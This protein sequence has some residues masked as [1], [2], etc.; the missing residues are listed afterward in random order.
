MK[1]IKSYLCFVPFL[2]RILVLV[3]MPIVSCGVECGLM[4]DYVMPV[5]PLLM[6]VVI[7]EVLADYWTFGGICAREFHGAE[8]LKSSVKGRGVLKTALFV[9][10]I[11]KAIWLILL[12]GVNVLC[13][14]QKTGE[15]VTNHVVRVMVGMVCSAYIAILIGNCVGRYVQNYGILLFVANLA[16]IVYIGI[17]F[18]FLGVPFLVCMLGVAVGFGLTY[19]SVWNVMRKMEEGYY[20]GES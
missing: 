11:R 1:A 19:F 4:L 3:F 2:Y 10:C 14:Q 8:Y 5:Y 16:G 6:L 7:V 9:D 13:W 17:S 15:P 12:A 18:V 20:D